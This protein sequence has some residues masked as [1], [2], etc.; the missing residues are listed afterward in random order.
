MS[1]RTEKRR[2]RSEAREKPLCMSGRFETAH[3]TLALAGGLVRIFCPVVESFLLMMIDAR[4]HF[5]LGCCVTAQLV[6][7]D[8]PWN[9]LK[10]LEQFAKELLRR[11]L[12]PPRLHQNIEHLAVLVDGAPQ[13]LQLAVDAKKNFIEMPP[14][15]ESAAAGTNPL[16]VHSAKLQAPL[17]HALIADCDATLRHHF[18]DVSV[19]ECKSKIKPSAMT[20]NYGRKAVAAVEGRVDDR[21]GHVA[22]ATRRVAS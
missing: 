18:F 15:A 22:I 7:D 2:Y 13:V 4:H 10:T 3:A 6:G 12:I 1:A 8:G 14:V 21:H 5:C 9:V 17:A 11:L 19:A 20:D 16:G